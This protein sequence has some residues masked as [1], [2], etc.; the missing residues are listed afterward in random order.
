MGNRT[1]VGRWKIEAFNGRLK[2]LEDDGRIRGGAA[3]IP[4][5]NH[6]RAVTLH[7][8]RLAI[9]VEWLLTHGVG[10]SSPLLP[11]LHVLHSRYCVLKR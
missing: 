4:T 1:D 3:R 6:S 11:I 2:E 10:S 9:L 5:Q 7:V 8:K